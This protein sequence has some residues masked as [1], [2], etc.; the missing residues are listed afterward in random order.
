[1]IFSTPPEITLAVCGV[2]RTSFFNACAGFG[3]SQ[4]LQQRAKLH[5][6]GNLTGRKILPDTNRSN[7]SKGHQ[8]ISFYIKSSDKPNHCLCQDRDAAKN[9]GNPCR[10]EW[11][12]KQIKDTDYERKAGNGQ[13]HNILFMPPSSI[14][15]ASFSTIF[16]M[17]YLLHIPIGVCVYYTP[18]GISLSRES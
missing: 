9:N 14:I 8:H 6:K 2:R 10:I 17:L 15:H 12:R 7:E 5:D 3:N 13:E 18:M 11:Q 16:F 1:M 4:V